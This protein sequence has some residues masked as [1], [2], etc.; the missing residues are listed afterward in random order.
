MGIC[1]AAKFQSHAGSIEAVPEAAGEGPGGLF[2]SHAGSI[3]AL[4]LGKG[5]S[6]HRRFNPTLVRLRRVS[7]CG[8]PRLLWGFQSHA[9]SI[10][11]SLITRSRGGGEIVSIPRWFD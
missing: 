5:N 1:R 8:P 6:P 10:E 11:A 4:P 9:G 3:E 7:G 2:Q